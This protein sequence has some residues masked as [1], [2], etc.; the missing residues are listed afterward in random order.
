MK[1][2]K[3][4]FTLVE[5][6]VV[7]AII[8]LLATIV[9]VALGSSKKKAHIAKGLQ[10]SSSIYNALGVEVGGVWSFNEGS[11][12]T[13]TDSSGKNNNGTL[14]NMVAGDWKCD[15]DETPSGKGCSLYFDGSNNNVEVPHNANNS[16]NPTDKLTIEAWVYPLSYRTSAII[17]AKYY[18][19]EQFIFRFYN[20]T[21][22]LQGYIRSGGSWHSC[23]TPSDKV[24]NL[25]TWSHVVYTYNGSIIKFYI[26]GQEAYSC[27]WTS[28]SYTYD[29]STTSLRIGS[30]SG[31]SW[32]SFHGYIDEVKVYKEGLSSSEIKS[33]YVQGLLQMGIS[34]IK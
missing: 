29:S 32:A 28:Q 31:G 24:V 16:L 30:Y 15:S 18:G 25:D 33:H 23:T 4:G 2:K 17:V 5:L 14:R 21:G 9:L 1:N 3:R 7:V 19:G 6:L 11:G 13:A 34:R 12:S 8:G 10:F 26:N 20:D 22:R 27:D